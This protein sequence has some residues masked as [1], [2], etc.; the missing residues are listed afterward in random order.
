MPLV[1]RY[2]QLDLPLD[3]EGLNSEFARWLAVKANARVHGTTGEVPDDR[4]A[5]ERKSLQALPPSLLT[6]E[7]RSSTP[8]RQPIPKFP[9]EQLQHP[10]SVYQDLLEPA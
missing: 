4:L 5:L 10:L 9:V 2:R 7:P 3:L 6:G 8:Q 1:S